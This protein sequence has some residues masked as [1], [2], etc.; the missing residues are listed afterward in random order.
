MGVVAFLSAKGSPGTTTAA[1]LAAALWPAPVLLVDADTEG[2]DVA[3]RMRREDGAAVD[4]TRGLLSLLPLARREMQPGTLPEHAQV[5]RGGIEAVAGPGR[6]GSGGRRRAPVDQPRRRVRRAPPTAT[7]SSTAAG[8][9]RSRRTCR[10]CSAPTSWSC[11]LRP[12]V[13]GVVHARERLAALQPA[14]VGPDGHVP[15]VGVVLVAERPRGRD[16]EGA[17]GVLARD[18]GGVDVLGRLA[19]DPAGAAVFDG[20]ELP[21]P[22]RTLLVRSGR[23][24]VE[25]LVVALRREQGGPAPAAEPP[26]EPVPDVETATRARPRRPAPPAVG[27]RP[28]ARG[29]VPRERRRPR[30]RPPAARPRSPSA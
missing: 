12:D 18:V 7:S 17:A 4:R 9:R 27:L 20:V 6:P 25:Q 10:C 30:P 26:P 8:C 23:E 11:V 28:P 22:E 3:L 15:R 13:S 14:L 5:L 2:G 16:A 29:T 24:M 1:L 19:H 21:R